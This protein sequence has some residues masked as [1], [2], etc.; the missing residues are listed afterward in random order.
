MARS[1]RV[2]SNQSRRS[3]VQRWQHGKRWSWTDRKAPGWSEFGEQQGLPIEVWNSRT[4]KWAEEAQD[5]GSTFALPEEP[6][7]FSFVL[8]NRARRKIVDRHPHSQRKLGSSPSTLP[9]SQKD[10]GLFGSDSEEERE[11]DKDLDKQRAILES[12]TASRAR[13]DPPPWVNAGVSDVSTGSTTR[14]ATQAI[15]VFHNPVWMRCLAGRPNPLQQEWRRSWPVESLLPPVHPARVRREEEEDT[16]FEKSAR[17]PPP[18]PH[19]SQGGRKGSRKRS[20]HRDRDRSRRRRRDG[21]HTSMRQK[22]AE[23]LKKFN[24]DCRSIYDKLKALKIPMDL[25]EIVEEGGTLDEDRF[26]KFTMPNRAATGLNY[27]RLMIRFL[28]WSE[29]RDMVQGNNVPVD[30]KLGVLEF[31]EHLVQSEC[32]FLTPRSFLYA[33]DFF[34][35]ALGFSPGG[36]RWNRAKRLAGTSRPGFPKATMIA[37]E[38]AVLDGFLSKPERVA[39]G[40]LRLCIQASTRFDDL[41]NAPMGCCEWVRRPGESAILGLRSRAARGKSGPRTWIAALSGVTAD[42]DDWL[43]VL[44]KLLV[45]AHGATPRRLERPGGDHAGC[46]FEGGPDFDSGVPTRIEGSASGADPWSRAEGRRQQYE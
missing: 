22:E 44:M 34:G 1:G 25:Q 32:G 16:V 4:T 18:P 26:R 8:Q 15:P 9:P 13:E 14:P 19:R 21:G 31:T 33:M 38:A 2:R 11:W 37:L 5:C 27:T 30:Q 36:G 17:P 46:V 35:N 39:C 29:G 6:W 3:N 41:L 24:A 43:P 23:D 10:Q 20:R 40:K 12:L 28:K 7:Q 45:E 42:H